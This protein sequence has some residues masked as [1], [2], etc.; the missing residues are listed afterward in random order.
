VTRWLA[1]ALLLSAAAKSIAASAA[2]A[3]AVK[4]QP[5]KSGGRT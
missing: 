5:A 4:P 1:Q 3:R 2:V